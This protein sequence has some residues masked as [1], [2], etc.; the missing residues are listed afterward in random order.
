MEI[1]QDA[2]DKYGLIGRHIDYSFSASYFAH[3]FKREGIAASYEN[4]DCETLDRVGAVLDDQTIKGY[5]VTIPYKEIVIPLLD[6]LDVHARAIGAVNTIKRNENGQLVGYNTDFIGF[7]QALLEQFSDQLDCSSK[8][9][10]KQLAL[11][12]GTGGASKA[13]VYALSQL[14]VSCQYVSRKQKN[15]WISY[16]D[17]DP[18]LMAQ[19]NLI[20]NCTP[21]GTYPN[22][23]D[24]PALPYEHLTTNHIAYDL[25]YN[26]ALTT[27]LAKAKA[28]NAYT[29]NGL[30]MLEIQ[31]EKAWEIWQQ[32]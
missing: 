15:N 7:Q 6:E 17:I 18:E 32:I 23:E 26:P 4:F 5:N 24:H 30:R 20:V 9:Q 10:N 12:L 29:I 27:F 2:M 25:I 1:K 11:I 8:E 3:K 16:P 19:T 22:T 28:Q 31:A 21:L 14:G 13:V